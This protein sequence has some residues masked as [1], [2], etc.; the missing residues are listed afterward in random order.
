MSRECSEI[1]ILFLLHI[2]TEFNIY[3]VGDISLVRELRLG[4]SKGRVSLIEY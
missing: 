3:S 1:I 2:V 4:N